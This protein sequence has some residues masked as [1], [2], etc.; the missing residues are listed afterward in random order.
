MVA[1]TARD[2]PSLVQFTGTDKTT[3]VYLWRCYTTV[4]KW[5]MADESES[6]SGHML[7]HPTQSMIY[8]PLL[9]NRFQKSVLII[10][11]YKI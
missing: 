10:V 5:R 6:K 9:V 7:F 11:Q 3:F 8:V 1:E 4:S 2:S